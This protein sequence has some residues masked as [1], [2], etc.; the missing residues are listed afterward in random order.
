MIRWA[1][2]AYDRDPCRISTIY[3]AMQLAAGAPL[4]SDPPRMD[5]DVLLLDT[6]V[7]AKADPMVK[8]VC[9]TWY[10]Q[11]GSM[12]QKADRLGMPSREAL[13]CARKIYIEYIRDRLRALGLDI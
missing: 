10:A 1:Q 2:Q 7:F 5:D 12:A 9:E 4:P 13:Y 8:K 6:Q 3:M 11:G